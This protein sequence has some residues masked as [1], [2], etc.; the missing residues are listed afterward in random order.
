MLRK[1]LGWTVAGLAAMVL[2]FV[3]LVI[4]GGF[5]IKDPEGNIAFG[6]DAEHHRFLVMQ[7]PTLA[8]DGPHAFL[9]DDMLAVLDTVA[10]PDG[11]WRLRWRRQAMTPGTRLEVRVGNAG[12]T[13]FMVPLRMAPQPQ[14]GVV[15]ALP[16]RLLMLS[17]FEGEFDRFVALLRAQGVLDADLHWRYGDG[18]VVLLGDLVD[19]GRDMV[20]LLWLVYRM[21]AEAAAVGGRVHYVLGNHE[22]FAVAG[23]KK[24]WPSHLVAT[25][26]AL[27]DD[28]DERLFS[29]QTVLGA[30]L[31]SRPVMLR[32]GDLL[33]VH[34][35]ISA[36]HLALGLGVAEVNAQAR[37]YLAMDPARLP[38][39]AQALV[40]RSG[41]TWYRGMAMPGDA[42]WSHE[43]DPAAHLRDALAHYGAKRLAIGHTLVPEITLEQEGRLLRLDVHHAAQLPQAALL[44]EGRLWRV[45]AD[46]GRVALE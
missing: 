7:K 45:D 24:Y 42:D 17:D 32:I 10:G 5:R 13:R 14:D 40:G 28:G 30:W 19:R 1:L 8:Q 39:Q 44:E 18:Q 3:A 22:Q 15:A 37:R 16:G 2:G 29:A 9:Q 35:G 34:A 33:F 36:D 23:T 31:R 11:A 25:A 26:K 6:W 38:A 27:G 12:N 21:E 4:F 20:P 46:G 41:V 43:A